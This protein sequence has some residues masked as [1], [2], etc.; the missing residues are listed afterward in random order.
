M[1]EG[2]YQRIEACESQEPQLNPALGLE[3]DLGDLGPT[4]TPP[5]HEQAQHKGPS[6]SKQE[7]VAA[8]HVG[9]GILGVLGDVARA[10]SEVQIHDVFGKHGDQREDRSCKA[11][12]D[13]LLD[14]FRRPRQDEGRRNDGSTKGRHADQWAELRTRQ[15]GQQGRTRD[16]KGQA[17][18]PPL[19]CEHARS[20][21]KVAGMVWV[22]T[23]PRPGSLVE[24]LVRPEGSRWPTGC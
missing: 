19:L 15:T 16:P 17:D 8:R 1:P 14:R 24:G 11:C 5:E 20:P 4:P 3:L 18:L 22:H 2:D 21:M 9:G 7:P 23:K 6:E 10:E 13:V 12:A